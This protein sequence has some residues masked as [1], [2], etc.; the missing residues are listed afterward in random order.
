MPKDHNVPMRKQTKILFAVLF[1]AISAFGVRVWLASAPRRPAPEPLYEGRPL[2]V[3]LRELDDFDT[4]KKHRALRVVEGIGTNGIPDLISM[5]KLKDPTSK[6]DMQ[7]AGNCICR[8]N[9]AH[10]LGQLG[11]Q[12]RSAIPHLVKLLEDRV[13]EVRYLAAQALGRIGPEAKDAVPKLMALQASDTDGGVFA[14][15]AAEEIQS[16]PHSEA[17][18]NAM[19]RATTN[20]EEAIGGPAVIVLRD[21]GR[22]GLAL[23]PLLGM[24]SVKGSGP[25]KE[26]GSWGIYPTCAADRIAMLGPYGKEAVGALMAALDTSDSLVRVSAARA[27]GE[28]GPEAK[29]ALPIMLAM[30]NAKDG[31]DWQGMGDKFWQKA[32]KRAV[33][34][35]DP[36]ALPQAGTK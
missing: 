19:A 13:P 30:L 20:Y 32:V 23:P 21:A 33:G 11:P 35:I 8:W 24:M 14:D 5:L 36:Q 7:L 18:L 26:S 4:T 12:A 15:W 27:L 17:V 22:A 31:K 3:W 16:Q 34:Q 6:S 28:I 2:R 9:A 29:P 10:T 1:V 25:Y